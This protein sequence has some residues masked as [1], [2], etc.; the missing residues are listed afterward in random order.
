MNRKLNLTVLSALLA[1]SAFSLAG[2]GDDD[3]ENPINPPAEDLAQL[4]AVHASP[5]APGVDIYVNDSTTPVVTNLVYG[6]ASPYLEVPAGPHTVQL[7]AHGADPAT[8]D[9][10]YEAD[11]T[12]AADQKVTAVAAGL[13]ASADP[14]DAFR[15]IPFLE[16]FADPGAGNA[17]VRIVHASAD[18]PSVALDVANDGTP[19]VLDFARFTDT[20]AAGVPLPAGTAIRIGVW[21]G[22][23]LARASVFTTPALPAGANLFVIATGLLAGDPADDGFSLL[24]VGPAGAIGFIRQDAKP[25]VY[26]L[27]ASPDAPAVDIDA[28]GAEVIA[29]LAFAELSGGLMV[30]PGAYELDFRAAGSPTVA[31]SAMTPYLEPGTAYLAI[32]TGCLRGGTPAFQLL[33][34]ADGFVGGATDAIVRIVHASPDAPAVDIGPVVGGDVTALADY[35]DLAFGEASPAAGTALPVGPLTVGVAATGTDDP[36]ATFDLAPYAGLRGFAVASGSLGGTGENFRLVLV[37]T[38][39]SEWAAVEVLP[40]E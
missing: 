29:D 38:E 28:N 22:D 36:V 10:V 9:P 39:G 25:T 11:V 31:A 19:E 3:D 27:H 23:P 20:G 24:A 32:A 5:D 33:P 6:S 35:T 18:A 17:A 15:I 12:L 30:W 8:T 1:F 40:N 37:V 7:R 4:R 34:V 26:A 14:A 21:A 13:L 16:E 2:C